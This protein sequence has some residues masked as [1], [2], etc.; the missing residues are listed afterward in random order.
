MSFL[1]LFVDIILLFLLIIIIGILY[2]DT[3]YFLTTKHEI[4]FS[5]PSFILY[6]RSLVNHLGGNSFPIS[7]IIVC[8]YYLDFIDIEPMN[9][10]STTVII[11]NY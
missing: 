6:Y 4:N 10:K 9:L 8:T 1:M 7:L 2:D 3:F 11:Y 5:E